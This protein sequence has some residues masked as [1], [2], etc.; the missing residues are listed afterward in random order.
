[1]SHNVPKAVLYYAEDSLEVEKGYG[2]DEVDLKL[3]DLSK[4]ENLMPSF[5]RINAKAT[6]PTL[7]VPYENTLSDDVQSRYKAVTDTPAIVAL[8]DK[9]RSALSK[10]HTTSTA[11]A[12]ILTPAT[13]AFQSISQAILNDVIY[14]PT[15]SPSALTYIDVRD[16][17]SLREKGPAYA[18]HLAR[19]KTALQDL[20]NDVELMVTDKVRARW[21]VELDET[22]DLL[23]VFTGPTDHEK[24]KAFLE[25]TSALWKTTIASD[26]ARLEKDV[27][28]PFVLGD[29]LSVVDLFVAG[30]FVHIAKVSWCQYGFDCVRKSAVASVTEDGATV[31]KKVASQAGMKGKLSKMA[32]FWDAMRERKSWSSV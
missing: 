28:G 1:M 17:A 14:A 10:T 20:L 26:L 8:L 29:Q 22:E 31:A 24:P 9:S 27:I 19:K 13:I 30:W 2:E 16:G 3:V 4:A 7:V 5:L 21:T 15:T 18:A 11:P 32:A 23:D 12:P 6:V 25:K